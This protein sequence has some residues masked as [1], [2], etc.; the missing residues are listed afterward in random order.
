MDN[1]EKTFDESIE[2]ILIKIIIEVIMIQGIEEILVV[3]I[4]IEIEV[5]IIII[6]LLFVHIPMHSFVSMIYKKW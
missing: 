2:E 4:N 6:I 3:I 5:E 1:T